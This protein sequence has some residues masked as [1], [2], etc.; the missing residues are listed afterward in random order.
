[1]HRRRSTAV[2]DKSAGLKAAYASGLRAL[3][4]ASAYCD[5]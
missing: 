2:F 3:P 4:C 5:T 1:M